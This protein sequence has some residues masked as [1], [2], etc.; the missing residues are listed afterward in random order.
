MSLIATV[1]M[2]S[3]RKLP[4]SESMFLLSV[5]WS[6]G[7]THFAVAPGMDLSVV[8]VTTGILSNHKCIS[9]LL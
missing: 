2:N 4:D 5:I 8:N 7:M 6:A 3:N 9:L 1:K